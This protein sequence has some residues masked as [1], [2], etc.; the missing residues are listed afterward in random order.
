MSEERCGGEVGSERG[1][2]WMHDR[3]YSKCIGVSVFRSVGVGVDVLK[4]L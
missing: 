1:N 4:L 2:A 3:R